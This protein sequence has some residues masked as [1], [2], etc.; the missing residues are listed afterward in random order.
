VATLG[1]EELVRQVLDDFR[2]SQLSD[3]E[4]ALFAYLE[5]VNSAAYKIRQTDIEELQRFGW[6]DEA[7]YDAVTVCSLFNFYNRWNDAM[8]TPDLPA[9]AYEMSGKRIASHGY[10]Q[11]QN[12]E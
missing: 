5:K 1:D 3:A 2:S 11:S 9:F 6:S 8:G 12:D 7:I 10:F 4:K